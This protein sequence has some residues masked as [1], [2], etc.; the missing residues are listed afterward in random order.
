M[1]PDR[2]E[3]YNV[4]GCRSFETLDYS[5]SEVGFEVVLV[6][7]LVLEGEGKP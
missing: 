1:R 7:L 4:P 6:D 5:E 3:G 2:H